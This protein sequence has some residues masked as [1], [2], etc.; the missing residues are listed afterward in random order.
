MKKTSLASKRVKREN[1]TILVSYFASADTLSSEEGRHQDPQPR[2]PLADCPPSTTPKTG[3]P[4]RPRSAGWL[5][6]RLSRW[7]SAADVSVASPPSECRI[8]SKTFAQTTATN[9]AYDCPQVDVALEKFGR[10]LQQSTYPLLT[11]SIVKLYGSQAA[12]G[13][14]G[15][16]LEGDLLPIPPQAGV[17]G[18]H[19]LGRRCLDA[20][21]GLPLVLRYG[22]VL[23]LGSVVHDDILA[24]NSQHPCRN[25]IN[26]IE[27]PYDA[28]ENITPPTNPYPLRQIA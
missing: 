2:K 15:S 16:F 17:C 25:D 23:I 8:I 28:D 22:I 3:T 6:P 7:F 18:L 20:D 19:I 24:E 27:Q 1:N 10:K 4:R 5:L 21:R 14:F 9:T 26:A 11:L 12:K 13:W